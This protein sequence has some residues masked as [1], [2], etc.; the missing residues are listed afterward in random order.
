MKFI[1]LTRKR[2]D[3]NPVVYINPE[4]IRALNDGIVYSTVYIGDADIWEV[5]ESPKEIM[6]LIKNAKNLNSIV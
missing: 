5:K 2:K 1:K 3:G 6:E 4:K